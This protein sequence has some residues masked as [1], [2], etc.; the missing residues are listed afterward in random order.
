MRWS[1]FALFKA[2]AVKIVSNVVDRMISHTLPKATTFAQK[3][4]NSIRN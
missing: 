3:T 4:I 1:K 2:E